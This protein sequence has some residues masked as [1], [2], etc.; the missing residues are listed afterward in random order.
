MGPFRP[1]PENAHLIRRILRP[2]PSN[3]VQFERLKANLVV[4]EI[5]GVKVIGSALKND[6]FHRSPSFMLDIAANE[7]KLTSLRGGD[8]V[9]RNLLQVEGTLNESRGIFEWIVGPEGLSHQRFIKDGRITGFPNQDPRLFQLW[10][11]YELFN[12]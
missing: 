7:G 2:D 5:K 9:V 12:Q 3:V 1:K 8:G 11:H 4:E 6:A 10:R